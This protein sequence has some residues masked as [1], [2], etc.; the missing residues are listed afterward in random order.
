MSLTDTTFTV[1]LEASASD[2]TK[3]KVGDQATVTLSGG[4]AQSTG[5]ISELDD[6]ISTDSVTK[7]QVYKGKITV[8]DLGAADGA[9]V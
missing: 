1:T 4:S 8:G 6:N 5:V 7:Q 3:L 9:T 2:R